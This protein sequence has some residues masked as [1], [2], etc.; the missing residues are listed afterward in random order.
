MKCCTD[1]GFRVKYQNM[2]QTFTVPRWS[3]LITPFLTFLSAQSLGLLSVKRLRILRPKQSL[4]RKSS[5]LKCGSSVCWGCGGGDGGVT[6]VNRMNS[7]RNDTTLQWLFTL[8]N[9]SDQISNNEMWL[10][11]TFPSGKGTSMVTYTA[12]SESWSLVQ[13]I[14]ETPCSAWGP[15]PD[16][17][18]EI[19]GN[20]PNIHV[21][22]V[23]KPT[24]TWG[25]HADST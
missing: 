7:W 10:M 2:L 23:R 9:N 3:V 5:C 20:R 8:M 16:L 19:T 21:V 22:M 4:Q 18:Q 11:F 6:N 25:E 1:V 17:S 15:T 12:N 14:P 24:W 13:R